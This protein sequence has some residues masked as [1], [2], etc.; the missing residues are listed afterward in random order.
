MGVC[1]M[2]NHCR[3]QNR[4][5][6]V[7]CAGDGCAGPRYDVHSSLSWHEQESPLAQSQRV[8]AMA[9][10][11]LRSRWPLPITERPLL[12][13]PRRRALAPVPALAPISPPRVVLYNSVAPARPDGSSGVR[14]C[15][16]SV[17]ATDLDRAR[18]RAA[19]RYVFCTSH[20]YGAEAHF[21]SVNE[22]KVLLQ[23]ASA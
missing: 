5:C 23:K 8:G 7:R 15:K 19:A 12:E 16:E 14:S 13:P 18:L 3:P 4:C 1:A 2:C 20:V 9:L 21:M 10:L 17:L 22:M 11:E 6:A